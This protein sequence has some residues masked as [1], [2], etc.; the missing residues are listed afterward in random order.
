[1]KMKSSCLYLDRSCR[2]HFR[3]KCFLDYNLFLL[4]QLHLWLSRLYLSDSYLIQVIQ[5]Y[6]ILSYFTR[7]F[8]DAGQ[9]RGEKNNKNEKAKLILFLLVVL[10]MTYKIVHQCE[11]K[12][13]I[14]TAMRK[15]RYNLIPHF[16]RRSRYPECGLKSAGC[17][18]Y[19]AL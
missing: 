9:R 14:W 1:M 13:K 3:L 11:K 8:L 7:E 16:R 15:K 18:L 10:M 2:T 17:G 4:V 6:L 12:G 5:L 19:P